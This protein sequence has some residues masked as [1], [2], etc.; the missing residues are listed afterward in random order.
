MMKSHLKIN[1]KKS[2]IKSALAE[3]FDKNSS[4]NYWWKLVNKEYLGRF[5]WWIFEENLW[6]KS[7]EANLIAEI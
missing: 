2:P 3:L 5:Y 7:A 1:D 4:R 6:V